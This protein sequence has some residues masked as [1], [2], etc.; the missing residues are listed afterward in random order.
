MYINPLLLQICIM[1]YIRDEK[2]E[3][4]RLLC[5]GFLQPMERKRTALD[6]TAKK[7]FFNCTTKLST[8]SY[9]PN[10]TE[11]LRTT[12][13]YNQLLQEFWDH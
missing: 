2:K 12:S 13:L 6:C 11:Q 3:K 5:Y 8:L 7:L 4:V 10:T 9:Y 1:D